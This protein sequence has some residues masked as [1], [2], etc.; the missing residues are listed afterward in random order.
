MNIAIYQMN[1]REVAMDK[2]KR[3][4]TARQL[5]LIRTEKEMYYLTMSVLANFL[6][7]LVPDVFLSKPAIYVGNGQFKNGLLYARGEIIYD[8]AILRF[9]FH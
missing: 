8:K 4:S 2:V 7:G 9:Q 1:A 3:E 6:F 5:P